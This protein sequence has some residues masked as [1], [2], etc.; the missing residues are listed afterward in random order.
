MYD[1]ATMAFFAAAAIG[2]CF[3]ACH[4]KHSGDNGP[5]ANEQMPAP[6]FVEAPRDPGCAGDSIAISASCTEAC[7]GVGCETYE[8]P[9]TFCC[10]A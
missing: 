4:H 3:A 6:L 8:D 10:T 2:T 9:V 1:G 7:V 5:R